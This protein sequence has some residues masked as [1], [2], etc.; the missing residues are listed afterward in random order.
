MRELN[1]A[2]QIIVSPFGERPAAPAEDDYRVLF[3][4]SEDDEG[5]GEPE[6]L[7]DLRRRRQRLADGAQTAPLEDLGRD[8]R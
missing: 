4:A 5:E 8:E 6:F 1:K 7:D 2:V 3:A